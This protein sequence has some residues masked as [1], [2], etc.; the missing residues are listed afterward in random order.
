MKSSQFRRY[1]K[2][3]SWDSKPFRFYKGISEYL[4]QQLEYG[5]DEWE[6]I[7]N[8]ENN[9]GYHIAC[10]HLDYRIIQLIKCGE[11]EDDENMK[12]DFKEEFSNLEEN[13]EDYY[14]DL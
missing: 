13:P 11:L 7:Y 4:K 8:D 1:V 9:G 12:E 14:N 3:Y 10:I 2:N 5:A 6:T